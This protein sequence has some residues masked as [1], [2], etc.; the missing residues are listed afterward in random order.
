MLF[1]FFLKRFYKNFFI[2][3]IILILI[4]ASSDM[5]LRLPAISSFSAGIMVFILM[6]PLMSQF[7]I[8]IA[9][10]LS[11]LMVIGNLYVED[12]ILL[13][14][15]F[16]KSRYALTKSL[17]VFSL[18]ILIL[19]VP[20]VTEFA[21]QT[22]KKGKQLILNLAQKHFASLCPKKFHNISSNF[23]I[24]FEKQLK[25]NQKLEFVKLLL[26][27]KE[28]SGQQY[29]VNAQ[30]G[31]LAN[32]ILLLK[33]GTIQNISLD[34]A[35]ISSFE[36][37]EINLNQFIDSQERFLDRKDLKFYT[38]RELNNL[39]NMQMDINRSDKTI[40]F[41]DILIEKN[42]RIAQI[43]WQFLFPFLSLFLI[44]YFAKSKS[45][46]LIGIFLSG[47]LF[48][49]SYILLNIIKTLAFLGY[50]AILLFYFPIIVLFILAFYFYNKKVGS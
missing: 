28:K 35:Y 49:I 8:P 24:F 32:N 43:L 12:E 13:I 11:V 18:S 44:I 15:Y 37:T 23:T 39:E 14:Y 10:C 30:S 25:N 29:I 21:P 36:K 16:R 22:Y 34:H 40:K 5:F 42:K 17:F 19:Y 9:S 26:F 4:L 33:N 7:A 50:G 31:F 1:T 6:L 41:L 2:Y 45:N 46:L 3:F 47:F 20:I 48:L 38:L 27:F